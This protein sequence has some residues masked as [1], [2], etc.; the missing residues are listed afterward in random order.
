MPSRCSTHPGT[1]TERHAVSLSLSILLHSNLPLQE[2]P[3]L[4]AY[5]SAAQVN[6]ACNVTYANES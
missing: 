3:L 1:L 6:C 2:E 5:Y 4:G